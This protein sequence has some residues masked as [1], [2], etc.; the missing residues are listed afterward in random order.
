MQPEI[1]VVRHSQF[2]NKLL[3]RVLAGN[4]KSLQD[5]INVETKWLK[6]DV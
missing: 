5:K 2:D 4:N 3:F 1:L 6:S